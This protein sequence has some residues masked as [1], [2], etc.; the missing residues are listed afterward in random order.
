MFKERITTRIDERKNMMANK[1]EK[2]EKKE[3]GDRRN[4]L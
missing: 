3:Y 2:E 4:K 1:R